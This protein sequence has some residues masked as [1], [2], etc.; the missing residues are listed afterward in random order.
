[1]PLTKGTCHLAHTPTVP[2]D[3]I[4]LTLP[5]HI[6]DPNAGTWLPCPSCHQIATPLWLYFWYVS[7]VVPAFALYML[8]KHVLLPYMSA[9]REPAAMDEATRKRLERQQ[10]RAERR[11]MKWR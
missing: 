10:Q 9:P 2:H 8:Y 1:M 6:P 5:W 7:L 4:N 3:V 11:K